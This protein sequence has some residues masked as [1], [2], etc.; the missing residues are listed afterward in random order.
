MMHFQLAGSG[1]MSAFYLH[2]SELSRRV[3]QLIRAAK[4]QLEALCAM[5]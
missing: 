3:K 4:K 2:E 1:V 5:K